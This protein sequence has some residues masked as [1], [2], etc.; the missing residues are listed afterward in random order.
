MSCMDILLYWLFLSKLTL[1]HDPFFLLAEINFFSVAMHELG[2]SLGLGH[3]SDAHNSIM[4][5]YYK[6]GHSSPSSGAAASAV[7]VH[8]GYDDV[9]GMY[10]L[11]SGYHLNRTPRC[12]DYA[13]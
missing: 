8:L 13:N 12:N 5:P 1:E 4:F 9:M 10:N 3:S 6:A 7:D 2:H 11:Y